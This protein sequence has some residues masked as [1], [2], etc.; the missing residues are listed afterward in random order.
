MSNTS[1]SEYCFMCHKKH[2]EKHRQQQH[3]ERAY[4]TVTWYLYIRCCCCVY[5]LCY[6]ILH[7]SSSYGDPLCFIL[8]K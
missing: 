2:S 8:A 4:V 5:L 7:L 3:Q 1:S 6:I